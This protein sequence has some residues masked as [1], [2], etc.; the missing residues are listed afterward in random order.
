MKLPEL[1]DLSRFPNAQ[2]FLDWLANSPKGHC[3]ICD[4]LTQNTKGGD[5][6]CGYEDVDSLGCS[7]VWTERKCGYEQPL[8]D[9]RPVE[10]RRLIEYNDYKSYIASYDWETKS[11][12]AK[13]KANYLCQRCGSHGSL[14]ELHTHHRTYKRLYKERLSDVE[15]LCATCH[16][17]HHGR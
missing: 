7:E 9:D 8:D 6:V 11:R 3:V 17:R 5:F 13:R 4:H 10:Y 15:V 16:R 14:R 12:V 2:S 1:F